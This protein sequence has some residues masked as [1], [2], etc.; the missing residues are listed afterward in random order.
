MKLVSKQRHGAKV[1][2]TYDQPTTPFQRLL[3]SKA[4]SRT[5]K[6]QLQRQYL[7]L[8]PSELKRRISKLQGRLWKLSAR[9]NV[10]DRSTS[11]PKKRPT[12]SWTL[13]QVF[14]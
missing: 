14:T 1:K 9:V 11:A 7:E 10:P 5:A 2:K 3:D 13:T 6:Q 12:K 8:N 4:L